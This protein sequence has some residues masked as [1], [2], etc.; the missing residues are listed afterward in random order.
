MTLHNGEV[1]IEEQDDNDDLS[2]MLAL[3]DAYDVE[4]ESAPQ[5]PI[6]TLVTRCAL[7]MQAKE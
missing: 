3:E 4:E 2:D 6:Y 7:N 5:G 1:V